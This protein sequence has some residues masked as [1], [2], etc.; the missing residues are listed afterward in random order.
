MLG[1]MHP[2][3]LQ[4]T[5]AWLEKAV[6]GLN[7]CPFAKAVHLRGQIRWVLCPARDPEALLQALVEELQL[8]A[9]A[10]PRQIETTPPLL[11]L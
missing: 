4:A 11:A 8:L 5:R 10:D 6:I 9:A 1:P 2:C 7:L 3:A